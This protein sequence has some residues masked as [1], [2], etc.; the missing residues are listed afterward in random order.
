MT[1]MS[2]QSQKLRAAAHDIK[3]HDTGE[4]TAPFRQAH[5]GAVTQ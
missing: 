5:D 1:G 2:L 4:A 3:A